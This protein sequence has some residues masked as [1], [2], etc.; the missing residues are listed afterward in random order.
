MVKLSYNSVV[1]SPDGFF[2]FYKC[3]C[4]EES[5]NQKFCFFAGEGGDSVPRSMCQS[6]R[7]KNKRKPV[8][9]MK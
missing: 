4:C 5:R 7:F 8:P 1:G 2:S 6:S 9:Q 3:M